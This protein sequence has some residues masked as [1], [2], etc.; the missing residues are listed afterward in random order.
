VRA[1]CAA[2]PGEEAAPT[3]ESRAGLLDGRA[4]L[5][6]PHGRACRI[7]LVRPELGAQEAGPVTNAKLACA[8]EP[9]T[10]ELRGG[11]GAEVLATLR[12][13]ADQW[14]AVR[15]PPEPD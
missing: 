1:V 7:G 9:C 5:Y 13:T 2:V 10:P 6:L 12:P 3:W 11:V 8:S 15:P 4:T 14:M